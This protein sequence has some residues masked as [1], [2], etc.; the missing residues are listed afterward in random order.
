MACCRTKRACSCHRHDKSPTGPALAN[1]GCR[2]CH[3]QI[4]PGSAPAANLALSNTQIPL[5]RPTNIGNGWAFFF[6]RPFLTSANRYQRPPPLP[7][8]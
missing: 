2:S 6:H 8:A 7:L 5:P 4:A 3:G 1:N